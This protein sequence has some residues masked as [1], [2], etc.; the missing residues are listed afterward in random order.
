MASKKLFGFWA[1]FDLLL[2]AAGVIAIL[3]SVL[4]SL[5]HNPLRNLVIT[6]S[7]TTAGLVLG[8]MLLVTFALSIGA[9]VQPNHVTLPL[10]ILNWAIIVDGLAV[11]VIGTMLWWPTLQER[12][13]FGKAFNATNDD[14]KLTLQDM[15]QCCGYF[16]P[17]ETGNVIMKGF[18]GD[19]KNFA[20]S[21]G[22]VGPVTQFADTTLNDI[23][24]TIYGYMGVLAGLFLGTLCVIK[25]RDEAER[26]RRIDA[27]RGGRGFV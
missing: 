8:V 23:F 20:N 11:I 13:N 5:S 2:L 16:F 9:I 27:K 24:T 17:N 1:F 4:W 26:F 21:S 10:S 18:C 19:S 12:N 22:C 15:L 7:E 6:K 25:T 3:F 14:I